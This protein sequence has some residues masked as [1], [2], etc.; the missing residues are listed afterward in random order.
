MAKIKVNKKAKRE[1]IRK[2][3]LSLVSRDGKLHPSVVVKAAKNNPVLKNE[4]TWDDKVAGHRWR[5]Y[6]AQNLIRSFHLKLVENNLPVYINE[7]VHVKSDK[8]GYRSIASVVASKSLRNSYAADLY[9]E[10][11]ALSSKLKIVRD[12][13]SYGKIIKAIDNYLKKNNKL[14]KAG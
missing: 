9:H 6:E 3:L 4:F 12:P 1:A 11:Q 2:E 5:I 8:E 13:S 7:F 10:L 14:A